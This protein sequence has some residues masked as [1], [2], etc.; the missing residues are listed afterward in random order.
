MALTAAALL[1][2]LNAF[3]H[4]RDGTTAVMPQGLALSAIV[5]L[6]LLVIGWRGWSVGTARPARLV[7]PRRPAAAMA[8]RPLA[9]T[10]R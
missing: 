7:A 2:F 9:G 8:P 1:S 3:V 10:G 5:A 6:L 4:S